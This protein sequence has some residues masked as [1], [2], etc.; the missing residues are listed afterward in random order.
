M[1]VVERHVQPLEGRSR[2]DVGAHDHGQRCAR[3][4]QSL[5][6]CGIVG[7]LGLDQLPAGMRWR[8]SAIIAENPLFEAALADVMENVVTIR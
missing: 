6:G 3:I 7:G 1:Y 4:P 5:A 2:K 8:N